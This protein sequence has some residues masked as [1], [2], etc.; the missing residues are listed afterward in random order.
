MD[1][2]APPS[3]FHVEAGVPYFDASED[4]TPIPHRLVESQP[5][6]FLADN[7]ETLDLRGPVPHWRGL[8]LNPVTNGPC[9][10]VDPALPRGRRRRRMAARRWLHRRPTSNRTP[11]QPNH[12]STP[13]A[14]TP[15][16]DRARG[17]HR[18][19]G[20]RRPCRDRHAVGVRVVPGLVDV[21]YL[22]WMP[23]PPPVRLLLHLPLAAAVLAAALVA[24]LATGALRQWWSQPIRLPERLSG[25]APCIDRVRHP[26]GGLA[27]GGPARLSRAFLADGPADAPIRDSRRPCQRPLGRDGGPCCPSGPRPRHPPGASTDGQTWLSGR[28]PSVEVPR[29]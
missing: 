7:G 26:A 19:G 25:P 1:P 29:R 11:A 12:L 18:R 24:L 20:S 5:G 6:L 21:G 17:H 16:D 8:R 28:S 15:T 4:G 13:L 9:G 3:R 14:R 2:T 10:P 23:F 27:P 22:G